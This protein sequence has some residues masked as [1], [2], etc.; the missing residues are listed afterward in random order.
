MIYIYIIYIHK[1][2]LKKI[3]LRCDKEPFVPELVDL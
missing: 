2:R 3:K 1:E